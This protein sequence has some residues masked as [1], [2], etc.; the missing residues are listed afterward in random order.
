MQADCQ[1]AVTEGL[2]HGNL[3]ALQADQSADDNIEQEC[4]DPEKDDRE[5]RGGGFLL[6][7]FLGQKAARE[8]VFTRVGADTA[9]RLQQG[10]KATD[11]ILFVAATDQGE[12]DIV[13]RAI[14]VIG[15]CQ[16]FL[17][18]PHDAVAFVIGKQCAG[19]DLVDVL[20]RHRQRDDV[21]RLAPT[22]DG[23][24]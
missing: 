8:L 1:I 3:F 21:E 7:E 5:Y 10:I 18:H 24:M 17:R 15:C 20:G 2:E 4:R 6:L 22:V 12:R 19:R 13:E 16:R 23:G 9:V 14:H 11:H